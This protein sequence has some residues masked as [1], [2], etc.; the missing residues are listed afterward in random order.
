MRVVKTS[1]KTQISSAEFVTWAAIL[2]ILIFSLIAIYA[3]IPYAYPQ[4]ANAV[5]TPQEKDIGTGQR[6]VK[7]IWDLPRSSD[8]SVTMLYRRAMDHRINP[9][10]SD[11]ESLWQPLVRLAPDSNFW[12]DKTAQ[13]SATYQYKIEFINSSGVESDPVILTVTV[14]ND[15]PPA[16]ATR[17]RLN[18]FD[19]KPPQ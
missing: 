13:I 18:G 2:F 10:L 12:T 3:V 8:V 17:F 15:E 14:M 7:L 1:A 4:S 6:G 16:P 5:W 11:P 9:D 19:P